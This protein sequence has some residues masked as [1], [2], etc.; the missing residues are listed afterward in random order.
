MFSVRWRYLSVL[1][2]SVVSIL[3]SARAY[4]VDA[5]R[6]QEDFPAC[7]VNHEPQYYCCETGMRMGDGN[8]VPMRE[9]YTRLNRPSGGDYGQ[10]YEAGWKKPRQVNF[11][12]DSAT[13]NTPVFRYDDPSSVC[14]IRRVAARFGGVEEVLQCAGEISGDSSDV[15]QNQSIS[16]DSQDFNAF[17]T[18]P[19]NPRNNNASFPTG[20]RCRSMMLSDGSVNQTARETCTSRPDRPRFRFTTFTEPLLLLVYIFYGFFVLYIAVWT[21]F[22]CGMERHRLA[23]ALRPSPNQSMRSGKFVVDHTPILML[24][25]MLAMRQSEVEL[26]ATANTMEQK[27]YRVSFA[28]A[29]LYSLYIVATLVLFPLMLVVILDNNRYFEPPLFDNMDILIIVYMVVWSI[30]AC[31]LTVLVICHRRLA[32]FFRLRESLSCCEFV[33]MFNPDRQEVLL[34]DH[35]GVASLVANLE[36]FLFPRAMHGYGETL[37]VRITPEGLRYVEFQHLRYVYDELY[38]KFVPGSIPLPD[39]YAQILEHSEG[40]TSGEYAKRVSMVGKNKIEIQM[41]TATKSIVD[42]V[43]RFFYV[44]ELMCYYVWYFTGYW[45]VASVN[46]VIIV[47]VIAFN[48]F[49]KRQ[50]YASVL[51]MAKP[52]RGIAVK[53]N[54]IWQTV[55]SADLVPGD[56]VR[57][58]EDEDVPCDMVVVQGSTVCD[59]SMLTGESLPIQKFSIPTGSNDM[60]V[61]ERS[62][63]KHT[64]FAGSKVLS[65]GSSRHGE[66]LAMVQATGAHTLHGQL[67][68]SILYPARVRFKYDEHLKAGVGILLIYGVAAG[69]LAVHYL[70]TNAGLTNTLFAFVYGMLLLSAVLN[71]LTPIVVTIGQVLASK[72]LSKQGVHCLNPQRV[73]LFGKVRVFAF[74]KTGTLTKDGLDFRGCVPLIEDQFAAEI[75]DSTSVE[76]PSE[77]QFAMASCHAIATLDDKLVGSEVEVKMFQST[78]WYFLYSEDMEPVMVSLDGSQQLQVLKRFE[79]DHDRMSMSVVVRH[80]GSGRLYVFTKGSYER[81]DELANPEE[82]EEEREPSGFARKA[83]SLAKEG[84]YVLGIGFNDVTHLSSNELNRLL[85]NRDLA[86]ADTKLLGLLV[87]QNELK[88]DTSEVIET[89]KRGDVRVIMVTGDNALTGCYI[90]R[91]SGMINEGARVFLGDILPTGARGGK[92]MVWKHID[93]ELTFTNREMLEMVKYK[94]QGGVGERESFELELAVTGPGFDYLVKMNEIQPLLFHIRIFSRMTPAGK[95]SCIVQHMANGAVTGMCGDGGNDCGA[96]RIAHVGV[97]LSDTEAS[98]VSPFTS[99]KRTITAVIDMCKEGRCSLATSFASLK[100]LVMY[101]LIGSGLRF[102]MYSNAVFISEWCFVF[103]DGFVLVGLSYGIAMA[104]PRKMLGKQRPTSSLIGPTTVLSL[105]GQEVIHVCFL[106]LGMSYLTSQSWY[107]PFNPQDVD[108]IETDPL[109]DTNLSTVIF[110]LIAPQQMIGAVAYSMGSRFRQPVWTNPSLIVYFALLVAFYLYLLV[111]E[112]SRVT[113]MFRIAS[114]TNVVGLPDIPLPIEFRWRLLGIVALNL[115]TVLVFEFAVMLGP[116]RDF[117]RKRWHRDALKL[118]L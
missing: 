12:G 97:S 63:K 33:H 68:Q 112:P 77:L 92:A 24:T 95:V 116:V 16:G 55:S 62:G 64:L 53:R 78:H 80:L 52:L 48:I 90:A 106:I 32:N 57:V 110:A 56:L 71:P 115:A 58:C 76:V 9:V 10:Y 81:L 44:Y 18:S 100:F 118:K 66:I 29:F 14:R 13:P 94:T 89:L 109:Q 69:C 30:T 91:Q 19:S 3:L 103:C 82:E 59:E 61:A 41:P 96:L 20:A 21:A 26:R 73:G 37:Q 88:A 15:Q 67:I 36:R 45:Y 111:G 42:E 114:S 104:S 113:E 75:H 117:C 28:G 65:S 49:V 31:W 99:Q 108:L 27:G 23:S 8:I 87:F 4:Q 84:C 1:T 70:M 51:R 83:E 25:P 38:G 101:G 98:V 5:A 35:S 50:M 74:D 2:A 7:A 102:A 54:G 6:A 40:L 60:Y 47:A 43:F 11:P 107:C 93:T 22:R 34:A 86:E 17:W 85:S 79:F 46:T 105:L 72:R 39:T